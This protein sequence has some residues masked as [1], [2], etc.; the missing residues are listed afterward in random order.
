MFGVG[1]GERIERQISAAQAETPE[2]GIGDLDGLLKQIDG[3]TGV[4][5]L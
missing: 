3:S 5:A 1:F 4:P 2:P